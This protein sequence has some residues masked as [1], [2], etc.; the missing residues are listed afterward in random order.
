[1]GYHQAA[2][3]DSSLCVC[4]RGGTC[5]R[6]L[7]SGWTTLGEPK[8]TYGLVPRPFWE[9]ET[10]WQLLRVQTV[11]GHIPH[12]SS[13]VHVILLIFSP[14]ENGPFLLVEATVCAGSATEGKQ[15]TNEQ[16][17]SC[18]APT[19]ARSSDQLL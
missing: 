15:K 11:Y 19:L 10:V 2:Q 14:A 7:T 5:R 16:K 6:E 17:S 12:S 18:R 13:E 8:S 4:V 3:N 1:M 9:G